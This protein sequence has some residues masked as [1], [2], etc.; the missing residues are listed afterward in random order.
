MNNMLSEALDYAARGWYVFPCREKPGTSYEKNGETITPTEKQPYV[1]GGLHSATIDVDQ[2]REWWG[3]WENA[4]IGVNAGQ[5]G[6]FVIDIDKKHV[7]GLDTFTAWNINDSAGLHSITPSGG[8]HI[9]F[10]GSGKSSTNGKTGVDTRGEG[11][12]FIAPPSRILEGEYVGEYKRFD[13]W[14]KEPGIIPDGLM[15]KLFPDRTTEYV[16]GNTSQILGN[17]KQLSRA[18]L[19]FLIEG[20]IS[21]ERNTTLFKVLADFAGCGYTQ[22]EAKETVTPVCVRIGMTSSEFEQVLIHAYSKPRTSSIPDAIQ[23]KIL[24]GDKNIASKI[25]FEEQE[26]IE[27]VLLACLLVDNKLIPIINDILN[28]EDFQV[29]QNR[30]IYKAISRLYNDG[31]KADYITVSNEVTKETDKISLDDISKMINQYFINTDHIT[32]YAYIIRE[33]ASIR[34]LESVMDNKSKYIKAGNLFEIVGNIEK[35]ISDIALYG[36]AKSTNVLTSKQAAEQVAERTRMLANGQI[37]Q[38]KT[39]FTEYDYHIGGL[40]SNDL[41]VCAARA[42]Q[43]KSAMALSILNHVSLV[44]NRATLFFS[45]EMS[46]HEGICRLVCQLTGIPYKNVYQGKMD[47]GQWASYK[48][49]MARI[50]DSK[51][52]FD[53]GFAMT[54]PEIRSKIRKLMEKDIRLI[55][56]DQ[57]EQVK[58]YEGQPTYIRYDNIAYEIKDFTKEFS[59]PIILNH[60]LNRGITD[61]KLKNPEPQ[62]AD[63]NQAGEKPADQVWAIV[64]NKDERGTILQSKVKLL[65]NRN[66]AQIEFP[67]IFVGERMLFSNP[68]REEDFHAFYNND[69]KQGSNSGQDG[70]AEPS[71][72]S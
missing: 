23:E 43:G 57:L 46:T 50:S 21:G 29:F 53:D 65:K 52:F 71:W 30:M 2:I 60:Q 41:V 66:G 38:L 24:S 22:E 5:S 16:R 61:R 7:N 59:V 20:A 33:K 58:G 37:E 11:G 4:L 42:G 17:K 18:T 25:S 69:N 49:A 12:Y 62:L 14:G 40:Y 63:L 44:Q 10:T 56:I 51:M 68:T 39:G 55:V 8:M 54:V 67:V 26:T 13:D 6:L 48:E 3:K 1:A 70:G 27:N 19:T 72:A 32:S 35:D 28:F 45:L 64:H 9:V 31:M 36:G 47:T 34:K 15:S